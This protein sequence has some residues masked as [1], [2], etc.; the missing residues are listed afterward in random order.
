MRRLVIAALVVVAVCAVAGWPWRP[1]A[2]VE[3]DLRQHRPNGPPTNMVSYGPEAYCLQVDRRQDHLR[4]NCPQPQQRDR[5]AEQLGLPA[6]QLERQ[7]LRHAAG[8]DVLAADHAE[9]LQ[10]GCTTHKGALIATSTQTLRRSLPAVGQ[11]QVH[12]RRRGEVDDPDEG[13]QERPRERRHLQLLARDAS[14]DGRVRDLVQHEPTDRP[15][16]SPSDSLNVAIT[17]GPSVGTS[18]DTSIWIDGATPKRWASASYTPA[19][20]FKA[21]N[22]S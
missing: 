13:V 18:I 4:R 6:G 10:R 21:G 1:T 19:V 2:S 5:H 12:R 17:D 14:R 3:R 16:A 9:H 22:A 15:R 8:S 20:Q 7:G 11:P